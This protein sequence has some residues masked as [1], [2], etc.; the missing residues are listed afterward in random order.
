MRLPSHT[1]AV[2]TNAV[3]LR[4]SALVERSTTMPASVYSLRGDTMFRSR[5]TAPRTGVSVRLVLRPLTWGVLVIVPTTS[6]DSTSGSVRRSHLTW[7]ST[8]ITVS[9]VALCMFASCSVA[10]EPSS[11]NPRGFALFLGRKFEPTPWRAVWQVVTC[12]KA[13]RQK[14]T[15][16]SDTMSERA[17]TLCAFRTLV[18]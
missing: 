4:L 1:L 5:S 7:P 11:L 10:K 3:P 12:Q 16:R 17:V 14:A 2:N 15:A 18:A 6:A 13:A 9:G 8:G